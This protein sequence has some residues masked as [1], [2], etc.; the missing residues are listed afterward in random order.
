MPE[1]DGRRTSQ[2]QDDRMALVSPDGYMVVCPSCRYRHEAL[3]VNGY[4]CPECGQ[5]IGV[6]P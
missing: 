2:E 1:Q 5:K 4:D 3:S 6:N